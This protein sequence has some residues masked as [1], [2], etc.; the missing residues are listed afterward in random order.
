MR[1]RLLA[2]L[3]QHYG[4][5]VLTAEIV[6]LRFAIRHFEHDPAVRG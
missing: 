5:P 2:R 4:Y 1:I 6:S 3:S